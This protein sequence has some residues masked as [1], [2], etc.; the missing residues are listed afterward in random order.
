MDRLWNEV[1]HWATYPIVGYSYR[2]CINGIN[3][4]NDQHPVYEWYRLWDVNIFLCSCTFLY[5]CCLISTVIIIIIIIILKQ[6]YKIQLAINKIEMAWLTGWLV[7][8]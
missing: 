7:V 4:K 5:E 1:E 6:D 8:G 3:S 2:C